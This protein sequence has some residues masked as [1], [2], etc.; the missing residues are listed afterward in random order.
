MMFFDLGDGHIAFRPR[1]GSIRDLEGMVPK[2][3]YVPSLDELRDGIAGAV[4]EELQKSVSGNVE[5]PKD[6][7][8]RSF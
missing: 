4:E 7:A 2:L 5:D 8:A 1:T 3:D 6:E